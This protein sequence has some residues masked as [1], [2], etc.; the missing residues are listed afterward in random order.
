MIVE[1]LLQMFT[2]IL[3]WITGLI[4]DMEMPGWFV[5]ADQPLAV[6]MGM[7][8]GLSPWANFPLMTACA[9]GV[10]GAWYLFAG[11]KGTRTAIGRR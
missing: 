6:L 5:D 3:L 4:P 2:N 10:G 1:F 9:L 7:L 11:I 8:S